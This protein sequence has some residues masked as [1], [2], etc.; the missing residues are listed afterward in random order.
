VNP[1]PGK[2]LSLISV[3]S[4]LF[5]TAL[6]AE[7][8]RWT[9]AQD[10][11][12]LCVI[13]DG[14]ERHNVKLFEHLEDSEAVQVA[15]SRGLEAVE[16]LQQSGA[17]ICFW[18]E[19]LSLV[20]YDRWR[21]SVFDAFEQ[22]SRFRHESLNE[23]FRNLQP[24]FRSHGIMKKND[25]L[26]RVAVKYLLEEVAFKVAAYYSGLFEGEILPKPESNLVMSIYNGEYILNGEKPKA[27]TYRI[28]LHD[29]AQ[30]VETMVR[31]SSARE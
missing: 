24:R 19:I 10:L 25:P 23:T 6:L 2:M 21:I 4:Q 26:V 9:K 8:S 15:H 14:P 3:G 31:T 18:S 28:V 16:R 12:L 29:G 17:T 11:D 7:Y 5:D 27:C 20:P 30:A 1:V 22:S 13:L